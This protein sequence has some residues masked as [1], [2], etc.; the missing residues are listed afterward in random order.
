MDVELK[1]LLQVG[2]VAAALGLAMA[3]VSGCGD[4]SGPSTEGD[5][6]DGPGGTPGS[7]VPVTDTLLT[8]GG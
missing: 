2:F 6:T 3:F 5:T 7:R 8:G 4:L 1:R